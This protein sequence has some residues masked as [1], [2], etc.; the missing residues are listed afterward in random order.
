[1][2]VP[3][4]TRQHSALQVGVTAEQP[5]IAEMGPAQLGPVDSLSGLMSAALDRGTGGIRGVQL[6]GMVPLML[7]ALG[8]LV[9]VFWHVEMP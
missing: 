5:E 3:W 1:M 7:W 2:Q 8:R 9:R 6:P 4:L